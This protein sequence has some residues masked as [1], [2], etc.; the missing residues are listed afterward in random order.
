[1]GESSSQQLTSRVLRK[2]PWVRR[3]GVSGKV[4]PAVNL[5]DGQV[6][7]PQAEHQELSEAVDSIL[8]SDTQDQ[9][10]FMTLK[11]E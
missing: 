4:I 5:M 9:I 2:A 6:C 3:A 10:M 1:M 7:N 11:T 8:P